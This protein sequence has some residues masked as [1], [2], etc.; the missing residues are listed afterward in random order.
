MENDSWIIVCAHVYDATK[1]Y[2]SEVERGRRMPRLITLKVLA[3]RLGM[4]LAH[5]RDGVPAWSCEHPDAHWVYRKRKNPLPA[6]TRK[7]LSRQS[8]SRVRRGSPR[9]GG[10]PENISGLLA[11]PRGALQNKAWR[12]KVG[13]ENPRVGGSTPSP[14][15]IHIKASGAVPVVAKFVSVA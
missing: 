12:M 10:S 9:L 2:I 13:T 14:G 1:S 6:P 3:R 11:Q 15:T 8:P 4:P 7:A 5:F